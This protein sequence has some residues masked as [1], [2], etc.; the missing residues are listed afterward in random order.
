MEA[1]STKP[2]APKPLTFTIKGGLKKTE[3]NADELRR[4]VQSTDEP[5]F[6]VTDEEENESVIL[7]EPLRALFSQ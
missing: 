5:A 4:F 3:F 2:E 6:V 1:I 7:V